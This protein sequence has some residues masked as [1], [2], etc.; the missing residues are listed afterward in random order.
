M[1]RLACALALLIAVPAARA[2]EPPPW[3]PAAPPRPGRASL[4]HARE[5][6]REAKIFGGVGIALFGGGVAV[7]VVALDLPQGERATRQPDGTIVSE[8]V[9]SDANWFELAGG[10]ALMATGFALV[11]VALLKLKQ[12]RRLESE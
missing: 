1:K 2:E 4:Q 3:M 9:R 7:N 11:S 6:R 12:A 5:L 8:R 10:I